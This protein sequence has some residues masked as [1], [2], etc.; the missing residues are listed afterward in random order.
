VEFKVLGPVAVS[1]GAEPVAVGGPKQRALL[2]ALLLAGGETVPRHRLVEAVWGTDPP[3]TAIQALQVYV[4]NLRR[5]LGRDRV[6]THGGGYRL[7]V[8]PGELDLSRARSLYSRARAALEADRPH[9]AGTA[10][11]EA[12]DLWRGP[13][14]A[15]LAD[16]PVAA[17][18]RSVDELQLALQE[19]LVD[20]E[21]AL[22]HH[23]R[24]LGSLDR[25]IAAEPYRERFREQQVLALYRAGRQND[26]L[27][28]YREARTQLV[29]DLGIEPGPGLQEL[30]RAVL[31]QDV[32]L[33]APSGRTPGVTALPRP[34]TPF[35]GRRLETAAVAALLQRSDVRLVTLTGAG[36]SGKTR[37][38]IAVAEEVASSYVDGVTFVDLSAAA[39]EDASV[40]TLAA[41]IGS[42]DIDVVDH[43]VHAEHLLVLDNLEQLRS[44]E[45][46]GRL[47][48]APRVRILATSRT[49]LRLTGEH[50][51]PVP[52]F[53]V[54]EAVRLFVAR[55]S[56]ADPS[57][58]LRDE[59]SAR[60]ICTR[61]DGLPL[62]I[63]LAAARVKIL[64][65]TTLADR[66]DSTFDV[67]GSG[68][69]DAPLR[70]QTLRAT[71]DWSHALLDEREQRAFAAVG[72]FPAAFT[73][74]AASAVAR[75]DLDVLASLLD[76]SLI[77]RDNHRFGMLATVRQYAREHTDAATFRRHAEYILAAAERYGDGLLAAGDD[78]LETLNAVEEM[79]ADAQQVLRW[80]RA[81]GEAEVEVRLA[82]ALRQYWVVR[83][84][85]A[86]GRRAFASAIAAARTTGSGSL[87]AAALAHGGVFAYRQGKFGDAR[88]MWQ[89]SLAL[90]RALGDEQEVGRSLAELGSVAI[91]TGDL[92]QAAK[93]YTEAA[94]L[95]RAGGAD[96]RLAMVLANLGAIAERR[97]DL[98]SAVALAEEAATIQ[99]QID[100]RDALAITLHNLG[101]TF[102][103]RGELERARATIAESYAIAHELGYLEVIAYCLAAAASISVAAGDA[104]RAA[105]LVGTARATFEASGAAIDNEEAET[106]RAT[107][108]AASSQL[109]KERC[110]ALLAEGQHAEPPT[111][112]AL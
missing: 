79:I 73:E 17:E 72:V 15:D 74:E 88:E 24:V 11:R 56:A 7:V 66:L 45:F 36:G 82:V 94:D 27:A 110:S 100:E 70:Q 19:T 9:D 50:E 52:P 59:P 68:A 33:A 65:L 90:H 23:E 2:A 102:Y 44:H 75:A 105:F 34:A 108:D 93:L 84:G 101:R 64:P 25:L 96:G 1:V 37:L 48:A 107:L 106:Q 71:L 77:R 85:I 112:L 89:E 99:R 46:V 29:D 109:G 81:H 92:D 55:A 53:D 86:E 63:E 103:A 62:A 87:L 13:A 12:L 35:L 40:A 28:A 49:P 54:D 39:D 43:L 5:A 47:L 97:G 98:T 60:R 4:H 58:D 76:H 18:A 95:F 78:L 22:G 51:Y 6:T 111:T 10:A 41:A 83:G 8:A 42:G 16:E 67:L 21:L 14:L 91:A 32:S 20:A 31:Q 38:A 61:L 80:A 104:E 26:A 57:F 30:H 3:S 69:R